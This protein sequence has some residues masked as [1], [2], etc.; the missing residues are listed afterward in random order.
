MGTFK[1]ERQTEG[2]NGNNSD[3]SICGEVPICARFKIPLPG[4]LG[5]AGVRT[6][7]EKP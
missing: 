1:F 7:I 6:P 2:T 5:T 3:F 4:D